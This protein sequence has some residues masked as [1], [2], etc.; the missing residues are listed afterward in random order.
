MPASRACVLQHGIRTGKAEGDLVDRLDQD[1]AIVASIVACAGNAIVGSA[2][3]SLLPIRSTNGRTTAAVALAPV[4]VLPKFQRRG[5]G[6]AMIEMGLNLCA[7]RGCHAA[8]VLGDPAY[9]GKFGFSTRLASPFDSVYKS[10]H[11]M[12]AEFTSGALAGASGIVAYPQAFAALED[13][14]QQSL[15]AESI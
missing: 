2:V 1:G 15:T 5:F 13:D 6:S 7:E 4:A 3:F 8:F 14:D 10:E 11:W 12:A 9:Y